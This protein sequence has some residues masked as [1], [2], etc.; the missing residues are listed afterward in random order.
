MRRHAFHIV[1]VSP[2]PIF[3]GFS[4]LFFA[5]NLLFFMHGVNFT[6]FDLFLSFLLLLL[7]LFLW[8]FDIVQEATFFG[9]HTLVVRRGLR[10]GVYFFFVSE[11]LL[12]FGFFWAF[13]HASWDPSIFIGGIWPPMEVNSI[14][15]QEFPLFNTVLLISSGLSVTWA[16][17]AIALGSYTMAID[18]F[19]ITILYGA[20]FL[21][22]Q[23]SEYFEAAFDFSDSV[24]ASV[25][26]VLT[27]LH[28]THVFI[29]VTFLFVCFLR[30]I[31]RHFLVLHYLG[32]VVAIWYWHFVD[33]VWVILFL[34]VYCF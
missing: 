21:F 24:Y 3:M 32:F 23:G 11:V 13:F 15:A 31:F 17:R 9:H 20:L 4:A 7:I 19:I 22:L 34:T 30:L 28:G 33:V 14:P 26:Y 18:S 6:G 16:H 2:W 1:D 27:G 25:F 8:F 29:G 12:F 5:L 10:Y